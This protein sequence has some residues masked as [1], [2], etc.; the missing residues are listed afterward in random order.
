MSAI[1]MYV[2]RPKSQNSLIKTL[3]KFPPIHHP[4]VYNTF[5]CCCMYAVYMYV[6]TYTCMYVKD[7]SYILSPG[8]F[9]F[10]GVRESGCTFVSI[11]V[12]RLTTVL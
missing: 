10:C 8:V 2:L 5:D 6:H 9:I 3:T 7:L 1:L 11:Y 4:I 12:L